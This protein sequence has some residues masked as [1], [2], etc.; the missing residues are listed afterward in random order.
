MASPKGYSSNQKV[1][2]ESNCREFSSMASPKGYSANHKVSF[3]FGKSDEPVKEPDSEKPTNHNITSYYS[4]QEPGNEK[5]TKLKSA[6][7]KIGQE[8]DNEK[9]MMPDSTGR[10]IVKESDHKKLTTLNSNGDEL[11]IESDNEKQT[12]LNRTGHEQ[13][14][15]LDRKKLTKPS[16]MGDEQGK[17]PNNIM[18][19][20]LTRNLTATKKATF[21]DSVKESKNC[22]EFSS[23][24]S[25]K[26]YSSNQKVQRE[27]NCREF[28]SMAS[29]KGYSAN[30]KVSFKF[31]KS[32]EPVKEPDSEKPT[33][34]NI[35]SYYSVQ[36]PGNEKPT[37]LKSAG[38]K[39]GQESDNEKPMMPDSTGREIVKESDHKKLTTLNSNGD[40]LG[41]ESDNEKQT[42]LNRT[43]HE[44]DKELDR[45]KLTKP[46]KMGDEQG[47]E[48]DNIMPMKLNKNSQ[49][50][51]KG[52]F[53]DSVKM[54]SLGP[55]KP[56][57]LKPHVN[58]QQFCLSTPLH[59][60]CKKTTKNITKE[61]VEKIKYL[62]EKI[63][64]L[65]TIQDVAQNTPL[66]YA[67][68]MGQ[69]FS[70]IDTLLHVNPEV[71][72][73]KNSVG[74]LPLHNACRYAACNPS[75]IHAL[76]ESYPEAIRSKDKYGR[77]PSFYN[78]KATEMF[79]KLQ[80]LKT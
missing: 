76:Y 61:D 38:D 15:E 3:K 47:K 48:L 58:L 4:V 17:E 36:E 46:S 23:M 65:T 28:S 14:K 26:G 16:K 21:A 50:T 51:K 39:I 43:G 64:S 52:T 8:S 24:A 67:C 27:S 73:V 60:L 18:P 25:P 13:D 62:S 49:A 68:L 2:R 11:G 31:G 35:T 22:R 40:E 72:L 9:P 44:Q 57:T 12:K 77:T 29:P 19:M 69:E 32:D 41:I 63:K 45:K 37:K 59:N 1:Q 7:D 54:M 80:S 30:H 70:V 66:H 53:A 10:E 6:G 34:H 55:K 78:A 56:K 42:K 79:D 75:V 33:N 5:P 20:K 74:S 71:C